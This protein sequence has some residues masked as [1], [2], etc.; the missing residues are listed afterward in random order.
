MDRRDGMMVRVIGVLNRVARGV[1]Y[2]AVFGVVAVFVSPGSTEEKG[3]A[4]VF[5]LILGVV[6][7]VAVRGL[8]SL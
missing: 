7:F 1:I 2:F 8:S 6:A 5:F 4:L 3:E